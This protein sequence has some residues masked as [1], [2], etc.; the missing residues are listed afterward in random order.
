[1]ENTNARATEIFN[2]CQSLIFKMW[3]SKD[4]N[5]D[6]RQTAIGNATMYF[7]KQVER[8]VITATHFEGYKNILYIILRDEVLKEF[9]KRGIQ[10]NMV[11]GRAASHLDD[12]IKEIEIPI[13]D[14]PDD[15]Y[16][17]QLK[18]FQTV[19]ENLTPQHRQIMDMYHE[20][21]SKQDI[22]TRLNLTYNF[23]RNVVNGFKK[24]VLKQYNAKDGVIL[25]IKIAPARLSYKEQIKPLLDQ[26]LDIESIAEHLGTSV[27]NIRS[28]LNQNRVK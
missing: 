19:L 11:T 6:E 28:H 3:Q 7:L 20:G 26:G 21:D 16:N 8:G 13:L 15:E 9:Q 27:G 14:E 24:A 23:I 12:H 22:A 25:P 10:K 18:A 4:M 5:E 17:K 1:M 2:H